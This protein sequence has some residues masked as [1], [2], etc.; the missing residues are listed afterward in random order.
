MKVELLKPQQSLTLKPQEDTQY[1]IIP[2]GETSVDV[3]LNKEGVS[4][5]LF[6]LFALKDND[7]V[8]LSTKSIH[9]SP[10][11]TCMVNV[12]GALFDSAASNYIGKIVIEKHAQQTVSFLEDNILAIGKKTKNTSQPI[13]EIEADD[14]KA[15]HGATT[16]R[17]G[18]EQ[19][20][21][22][23]ARGLTEKEAEK[24]AITGFF[25]SLLV[26]IKDE[27]IREKVRV[28]LNL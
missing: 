11:T 19:L 7:M 1:V 3:I 21:Y 10:H 6:A 5:E 24:F 23:M 25:E 27:K 22:L 18:K 2:E 14:V 26:Q 28:E 17:I 9:K 20:Y 13:L 4:A 8:K 15:S 12:K 16:G